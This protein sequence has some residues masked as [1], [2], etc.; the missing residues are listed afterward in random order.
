MHS[1][2][3][4][5]LSI[6]IVSWNTRDLLDQCLESVYASS[7]GL[8][9]ETIVVDNA[10]D[11]GSADMV[12]SRYPD[13]ELIQNRMNLG[14]AA[15]CNLAFKHSTGRYFLLLN[16]DT[17]VLGGALKAM[18]EFM[19]SHPDAGAAG[20]RLLN[21]DGSLQR[22]CSRFPDLITELFDALYLSK[23]F[24]KSRLFGC[25]SMSYWGFD[26][27]REVDFAGGSCLIVRR[28]AVEEV[29]LLD[30]GFFMYT[31]EADWCYRMWE[32]GWKVYY[33]PDAQVIHLGGESVR[34]Y[35]S[36][37]LLQLYASRNRFI[38]KHRGSMAAAAHR[39]IVGL[40]ALCRLSVFGI[41]RSASGGRAEL[42]EAAAFQR[43]LLRWTLKGPFDQCVMANPEG[44]A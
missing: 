20:C 27:V 41:R 19:D 6:A 44:G 29:G 32:Q 25:Y 36:D 13:V 8:G 10:S 14:F 7:A 28:E 33:F 9:F 34:R 43:R 39:T 23:L 16:S 5:D 4:K 2:P 26:E 17:I 18:I 30:E 22:S 21:R 12:A 35:G 38:R 24:P 37:I 15:A 42:A 11:D 40:G 3:L 1:R 31:E